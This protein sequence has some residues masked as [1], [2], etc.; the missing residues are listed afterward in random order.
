MHRAEWQHFF[1]I[2][3]Q[4][5]KNPRI[6]V[7]L[8]NWFWKTNNTRNMTALAVHCHAYLSLMSWAMFP[9][10]HSMCSFHT[11]LIS[12]PCGGSSVYLDL[13][14]TAYSLLHINITTYKLGGLYLEVGFWKIVRGAGFSSLL[15]ADASVTGCGGEGTNALVCGL[16]LTK[17]GWFLLFPNWGKELW[18]QKILWQQNVI[19]HQPF[20]ID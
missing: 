8:Q 10:K 19:F 3:D 17:P 14:D 13:L 12:S 20:L 1:G 18:E 15:T 2:K 9:V 16:I 4:I 5:L 7:C 6:L 11:A